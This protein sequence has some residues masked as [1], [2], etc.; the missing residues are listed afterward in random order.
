M[1]TDDDVVNGMIEQL[2]RDLNG[3]HDEILRLQGCKPED[4]SRYDWPEWTP[5][6]N[7]IRW[8]EKRLGKKLAKTDAWTMFPV[9][10]TP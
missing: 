2:C 1:T 3:A 10:G 4:L 6:A 5:Q 8:A 9:K 7:S